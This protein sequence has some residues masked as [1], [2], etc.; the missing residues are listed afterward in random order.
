MIE[1]KKQSKKNFS[2]FLSSNLVRILTIISSI[3]LV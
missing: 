3:Y 1:Q 2:V